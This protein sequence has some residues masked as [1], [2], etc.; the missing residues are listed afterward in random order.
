MIFTNFFK[1]KWQH[2]DANIRLSAIA[3]E[4]AVEE[5]SQKSIL[6]DLANHDENDN[7]RKAALLKLNDVTLFLDI[8]K[9]NDNKA[10]QQFSLK[11]LQSMLS[12]NN[13]VVGEQTKLAL[14]EQ[15]PKSF[16]E[17]WILTEPE[18]NVVKAI[19]QKIA[20]P[21]TTMSLFANKQNQAFQLFLIDGITDPAQL[22]K[23]AK[24]S[25]IAAV[26]SAIEEKVS[27]IKHARELPI[28]L[29]K[30]VQLSLS[31]L[32]AL[33]D[34]NDNY[35][36]VIAKRTAI[37]AEWL[38]ALE[39]FE[40]LA[41]SDREAFNN[42]YQTISVQLDKAFVQ[43]EEV[44]QQQLIA[45]QLADDKLIAKKSISAQLNA[46]EQILANAVFENTDLNNS[47][48][49]TQLN[50]LPAE[51]NASVLSDSEKTGF[52]QQVIKLQNKLE[53]LPAIAQSVT[54]ATHL[55][56]KVSQLAMPTTLAELNDKQQTFKLW[57]QQWREIEKLSIGTLPDS[58]KSAKKEIV[59]Q[60]DQALSPLLAEQKQYLNHTRK[61]IADL[62]RL[63]ANGKFNA[64]FGIFKKLKSNFSVLPASGQ[65][66][67]QRDFDALTEKME[68]LSD[69]EHYIATPRKQELLNDIKAIVETPLDNPKEQANKV[70]EYR[71][72]W[73]SLGHA[74]DDVEKLLNDEFN[75]ACEQAFAPCRLFFSEQEKIR[76]QHAKSRMLI[77]EQVTQLANT[78]SV[79]TDYK[80]LE[81]QV[82]KLNKQWRE[83]GEVERGQYQTLLK[84]FN[85]AL[86]PVKAAITVFHQENIA[87]KKALV[88]KTKQIIAAGLTLDNVFS[89]TNTI[90]ELQQQWRTIGYAG[91]K[92]DNSLWQEFRRLNDQVF[93]ERD[94]LKKLQSVEQ[95]QV[96]TQY[97]SELAQLSS[98]LTP[99]SSVAQN[100]E[101]LTQ[102]QALQAQVMAQKPV[103]K[104]LV[105][106]IEK[107]IEAINQANKKSKKVKHQLDW[108]NIFNLLT[109]L[110]TT[111]TID[112]TE[113]AE[114]NSL[115]TFWQKKVIDATKS[116]K[117]ANGARLAKTLELEILGG[118]ESPKE[119]AAERLA[120]QVELMQE[121][122]V[123]SNEIDLQALFIQWLLL[124]DFTA[125]D[126][127]L[128][129]RIKPLFC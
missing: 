62:K 112:I 24:K 17:S 90:K 83:A 101:L 46:L 42:K 103:L 94:E 49:E 9:E 99:Q 53:Q 89:A 12:K 116:S 38:V 122:M 48:F 59:A 37:E 96:K 33:K 14:I 123:S 108:Q 57:L 6:L 58:I 40:C 3:N 20:K 50:A 67:L 93:A 61:N 84:Q 121:Q 98:Q 75:L 56:S 86:S 27:A 68:D 77:I 4:L 76:E 28:Q 15:F 95:E 5:S 70:K 78:L 114:F 118:I 115:S 97:A 51:I 92:Q 81:A 120:K 109:Q 43:K 22:E 2:K 91:A 71:K 63:I 19:Y 72:L 47:E 10:I 13:A 8:S 105:G 39:Q 31:K 102:A 18:I 74:E 66:K 44:Y 25:D 32:L 82:N 21:Q 7:V 35:D 54:D 11:Q 126:V 69:W 110:A 104:G 23:L 100:A 106:Q 34:S 73:N 87:A 26:V 60:W 127:K 128:I 129:E 65:L 45:K 55:I 85:L 16:L 107:F 111:P 79:E 29:A 52:K 124:G 117:Q 119:F 64:C 113:L 36:V 80:Q 88:D 125:D 30:N 41:E 1:A